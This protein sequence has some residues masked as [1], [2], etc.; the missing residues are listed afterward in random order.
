M[1]GASVDA[2]RSAR[3]G[4]DPKV[5]LGAFRTSARSLAMSAL[6]WRPHRARARVPES[7]RGL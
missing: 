4:G 5:R 3:V 7:A 1:I 6:P 2:D